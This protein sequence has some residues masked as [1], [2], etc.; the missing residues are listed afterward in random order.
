VKST[1]ATIK[2]FVGA[3]REFHDFGNGFK[4][5]GHYTV[6]EAALSGKTCPRTVPDC[7]SVCIDSSLYHQ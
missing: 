5:V 4:F 6:D 1:C 2:T 3:T 7:S